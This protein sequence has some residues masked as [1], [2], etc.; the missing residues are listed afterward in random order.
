MLAGDLGVLVVAVLV[1]GCGRVGL[2]VIS[3][4]WSDKRDHN[5]PKYLVWQ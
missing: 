2:I 3:F 4:S 1:S 5:P